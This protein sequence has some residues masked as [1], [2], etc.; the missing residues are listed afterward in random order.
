MNNNN[1]ENIFVELTMTNNC[2]CNCQYCFE[3]NHPI[4]QRNIDEEQRQLDLLVDLCN[5]YDT[6]KYGWLTISFWGGEPFLNTEFMFKIIEATYKYEFVR[7]HIYSNGTLIH[8]Y[9]ELLCK[10]FIPDIKGRLH[11]QLSYDGEPHHTIKRANNSDKIFTVAKMLKQANVKFDFKATLSFDMICH[12]PEIWKSY[13]KLYE[14]F[15]N[16]V[17]YHPTLDTTFDSLEYY[18]Q[19]KNALKQIIKYEYSFVKKHKQ[20]LWSWFSEN[21]KRNCMLGNSIFIHNDGNIYI[22][23]GCAYKNENQN[24]KIGNTHDIGSLNNVISNQYHFDKLP[25]EC[26]NCCATSCSVCHIINITPYEDPHQEWLE[27]RIR[28]VN[29]CQYFKY[30]GVISHILKYL[31]MQ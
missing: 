8:K 26:I 24:L 3:G 12:L 25:D 17:R 6:N 29:R 30:F 4:E 13:E 23:H 1:K 2:N 18:D 7:Y 5:S 9:K 28:K 31:C 16:I 22:C 19:W 20:P 21:S 10:D 27:C 11:I 14:E 15:G